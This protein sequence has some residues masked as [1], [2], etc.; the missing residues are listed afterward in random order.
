M[1]RKILLLGLLRQFDMY[2]YKLNEFIDTH[3]ETSIQL[4][5]PTTYRI[6]HK[7]A[8][9][10]WIEFKEVQEGNRPFKRIYSI[11]S[12]GELEFQKL[13]RKS[14]SNYEPSEYRSA[15]SLAFVDALPLDEVVS[16]LEKR[17]ELLKKILQTTQKNAE[18][19]GHFNLLID[20]RIRHLSTELEW[21]NE[22][23][24]HFKSGKMAEIK[25]K[26]N[27][28]KIKEFKQ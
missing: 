26:V 6:L 9:E 16:L 14:L 8:E 20:H 22:I 17:R 13:L 11:T 5:K 25:F 10:G 28:K 2:G 27:N 7:M 23:I 24:D 15:I 21:L 4:K 18:G 12:Q 1:E 19:H 3:I